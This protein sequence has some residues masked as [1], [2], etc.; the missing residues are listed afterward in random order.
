MELVLSVHHGALGESDS[1]CLAWWQCLYP[2]SHLSEP[3]VIVFNR[4][5]ILLCCLDSRDLGPGSPVATSLGI[6]LNVGVFAMKDGQLE[7][8]RSFSVLLAL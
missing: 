5:G 4:R 1:G 2:L 7:G 8:V 3:R 6:I